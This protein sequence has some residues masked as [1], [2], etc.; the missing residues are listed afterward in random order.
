MNYR[1]ENEN[2]LTV[3]LS[4]FQWEVMKLP[5]LQPVDNC[6]YLAGEWLESKYTNLLDLGAGLGRNAIY[7]SK[8]G[9]RVSAM[10]VSE[11]GIEYLKKWAAKEGFSIDTKVGDM[12][13][14]PYPD[15]SFD[16]IFA[17]H[18]I[19]HTDSLGIKKVISEIE[20]FNRAYE[21]I[22]D[23][24]CRFVSIIDKISVEMIGD[25]DESIIIIEKRLH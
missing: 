1:K 11:Y 6:F 20:K 25:N 19:S 7:F 13:C 2:D 21:D 12:L 17:Y 22:K 4:G 14:L 5:D 10:D 16:C 23:N 18:V 3:N 24:A 9:F 15:Q 8:Q